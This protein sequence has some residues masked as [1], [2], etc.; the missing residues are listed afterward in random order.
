MI[1]AIKSHLESGDGLLIGRCGTIEFETV[2]WNHINPSKKWP[3]NYTTVLERNA[4][5]FPASSVP[6]T[7]RWCIDTRQAILASSLFACGWYAPIVE[8]EKKMLEDWGFKGQKIVLRDLE[9]YYKPVEERWTSLL[10]GKRVCVVSSF[11]ETIKSQLAKGEEALWPGANGS[12]LPKAKWHFV[13]TGY[14]PCLSLGKCNWP[15]DDA[16][17]WTDAVDY[18]VRS[19][20]PEVE[21]VLIG[22]GG[23]GMPI[24][25]ELRDR[26]KICIVMG[27]AIQVLFGIKGKR[28]QTHPIISKFWN[29]NWVWPADEEIPGGAAEVE[30]S[31]YWK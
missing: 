1:A 11:T 5:V 16:E 17:S 6:H 22:C 4:G 10:A 28:W 18:V 2:Y 21:I 12:L 25:K 27:G 8:A 30:N 31:C 24:A 15:I 7:L 3:E 13:Q 29:S 23:L 26:G 9:P 20:K 14:S 19:I